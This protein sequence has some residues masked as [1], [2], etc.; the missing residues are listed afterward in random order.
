MSSNL[1]PDLS[2]EEKQAPSQAQLEQA[3]RLQQQVTFAAAHQGHQ[4]QGHVDIGELPAGDS[5]YKKINSELG[6]A[7]GL[8]ML[9]QQQLSSYWEDAKAC[10][11]GMGGSSSTG[12]TSSAGQLQRSTSAQMHR[13]K[14]RE[15]HVLT[16]ACCLSSTGA[17]QSG[18]PS[19][20]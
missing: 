16:C 12:L 20:K 18:P 7:L 11:A 9:Q 6:P 15:R 19:A 14:K 5:L 1:K 17:V 13:G 10:T 2:Q 3:R 8:S 4:P